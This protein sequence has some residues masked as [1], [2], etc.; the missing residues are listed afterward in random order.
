MLSR[1]FRTALENGTSGGPSGGKLVLSPVI[2][3]V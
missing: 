2:D 1:L 3:K